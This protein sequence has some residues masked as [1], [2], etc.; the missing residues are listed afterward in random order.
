MRDTTTVGQSTASAERPTSPRAKRIVA[1]IEVG[2]RGRRRDAAVPWQDEALADETK[3]GVQARRDGRVVGPCTAAKT[4]PA[5]SSPHAVARAPS[6]RGRK[7]QGRTAARCRAAAVGAPASSVWI[8]LV[9]TAAMAASST[10]LST[11]EYEERAEH[12]Q[13]VQRIRCDRDC[14]GQ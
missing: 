1:S 5:A 4:T 2:E 13:S 7:G 11:R 10:K 3:H 12:R 14:G 8:A 6:R 9:M